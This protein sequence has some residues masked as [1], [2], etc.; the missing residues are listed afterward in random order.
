MSCKYWGWTNRFSPVQQ[1]SFQRF[2]QK[3]YA[4]NIFAFWFRLPGEKSSSEWNKKN[5]F[6]RFIHPK[7]KRKKKLRLNFI[8][9][10]LHSLHLL[11]S[12]WS[13]PEQRGRSRWGGGSD[14]GAGVW[15]YTPEFNA[16]CVQGRDAQHRS[17][18]SLLNLFLP[19]LPFQHLWICRCLPSSHDTV[20]YNITH[21]HTLLVIQSVNKSSQK[22]SC[23]SSSLCNAHKLP[24]GAPLS[25]LYASGPRTH[26]H[27]QVRQLCK[28]LWKRDFWH[29][30]LVWIRIR[31]GLET[32]FR[33]N[34][35][36][37][38]HDW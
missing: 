8:F 32:G 24:H 19:R 20:C 27:L 5:A 15:T 17:C 25:K 28:A 1:G 6:Q 16:S 9:F 18:C 3:I 38:P 36:G 12:I 11:W 34:L 37:D 26:D 2:G 22:V 30:Y 4:L 21:H 35:Q 23:S 33:L 29:F 14:P 10:W 31:S 13:A 7:K